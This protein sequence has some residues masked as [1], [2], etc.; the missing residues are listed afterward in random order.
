MEEKKTD[1]EEYQQSLMGTE[2]IQ[3]NKKQIILQTLITDKKKENKEEFKKSLEFDDNIVKINS[4]SSS[5]EE[6]KEEE[7]EHWRQRKPLKLKISHM[8]DIIEYSENVILN[9]DVLL[10]KVNID[11]LMFT[12]GM[13]LVSYDTLLQ[14]VCVIHKCSKEEAESRY[15]MT[16][17]EL[18]KK[19]GDKQSKSSKYEKFF[20]RELL[21]FW[22][23]CY[24]KNQSSM[25]FKNTIAREWCVCIWLAKWSI[26]V[27]WATE[28]EILS[29][30]WNDNLLAIGLLLKN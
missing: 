4:V 27:F 23:G 24:L 29:M 17:E 21:P 12:K 19:M 8:W 25:I 15:F 16:K 28:R 26:A 1:L 9:E 11:T 13:Q 22:I 5:K 30:D 6:W 7:W 10:W 20:R 18:E 2:Q 3:G 14:E